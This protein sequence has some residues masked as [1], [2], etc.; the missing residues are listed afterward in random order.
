MNQNLESD[1]VQTFMTRIPVM[2]FTFLYTIFLIRLLGPEGNGIYTYITTSVTLTTLI[3][4]FN[5][6]P[7]SL[8]F[9]S[10]KDFNSA[11]I[12]GLAVLI[13]IFSILSVL[14]FLILAFFTE[15]ALLNLIIPKE[16]FSTFYVIFYFC[17]FGLLSITSIFET[18]LKSQRKFKVYNIY[19]FSNHLFQLIIYGLGFC[20]AFFIE[21]SVGT[22][23][24]FA[25]I[26]IIQLLI[27]IYACILFIKF[28]DIRIDFHTNQVRKP[29]FKYA[30]LGYVNS[31]G[32]FLNKRLDVWFVEFYAGIKNLGYYALATQL[33]NFLLISITPLNDVLLPYLTNMDRK[34]GNKVFGVYIRLVFAFMLTT[35]LTLFLLSGFIVPLLFGKAFT[36]SIIPLKILCIGLVFISLRRLFMCYNRAYNDLRYNVW[37]QWS[38]VAITLV[39]DILLIPK[40]GI[41]GAAWASVAA[42]S[43]TCI[44]IATIIMINQKLSIFELLIPKKTDLIWIKKQLDFGRFK[45]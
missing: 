28:T 36:F 14:L 4:S 44:F 32:H 13:Y 9:L 17:S 30:S 8:Y 27:A 20:I 41:M 1:S 31:L 24:I 21:M 23:Q 40:Y 12:F 33:T 5:V 6:G 29:F 43:A 45:K 42:Y 2:L 26:L 11:K 39:L 38:G 3:V 35:S 10:N 7:S 22:I 16:N 25:L 15:D 37:A 19:L 18:T 34:E